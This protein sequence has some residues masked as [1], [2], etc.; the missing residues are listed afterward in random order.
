LATSD[1]EKVLTML[2]GIG[3]GAPDVATQHINPK[4][5]IEH[6]PRSADGVEGLKEY[7]SRVSQENHHLK[8]VRA[9]QDGPYVVTHGEGLI[10]PN[11]GKDLR[12]H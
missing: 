3:S 6:N 12:R 4:K 5:Y 11:W 7:I 10:L 1:I 8:M 9:F 2:Q